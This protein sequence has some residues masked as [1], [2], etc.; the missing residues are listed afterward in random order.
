MSMEHIERYIE[1]LEAIRNYPKVVK[2]RDKLS[3][4]L[5]RWKPALRVSLRSLHGIRN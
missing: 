1:E 3:R 2:E 5:L 4:G